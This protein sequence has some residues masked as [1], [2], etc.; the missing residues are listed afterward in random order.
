MGVHH[1]F[2]DQDGPGEHRRTE[3]SRCAPGPRHVRT[4]SRPGPAPAWRPPGRTYR[5]KNPG[6]RRTR[7]R[8]H[9]WPPAMTTS[10]RRCSR[11]RSGQVPGVALIPGRC[12]EPGLGQR[13]LVGEVQTQDGAPGES[14][15][16]LTVARPVQPGRRPRQQHRT[17]TGE[18]GPTD[19]HDGQAPARRRRHQPPQRVPGDLGRAGHPGAGHAGEQP[20]TDHRPPL[21]G[22]EARH[23]AHHPAPSIYPASKHGIVGFTKPP[24]PELAH[25]GITVNAPCPGYAGDA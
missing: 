4:T 11:G 10:N 18:G 23:R 2:Q 20:G 13:R 19:G 17:P 14:R 21:H 22:P 12:R 6:T 8:S 3:L 15:F 9:W 25:T 5:K 1:P 16:G 7:A 24:G